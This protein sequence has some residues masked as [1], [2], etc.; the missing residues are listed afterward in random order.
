MDFIAQLYPFVALGNTEAVA[1]FLSSADYTADEAVFGAIPFGEALTVVSPTVSTHFLL[2]IKEA[3]ESTDAALA[4]PPK[5]DI[6]LL[7]TAEAP[8][9]KL[10]KIT[11]VLRDSASYPHIF[12]YSRED[13]LQN[14]RTVLKVPPER[15]EIIF[16]AIQ[17]GELYF[18]PHLSE[19]MAILDIDQTGLLIDILLEKIGPLKKKVEEG[20][21]ASVDETFSLQNARNLAKSLA[22]RAYHFVEPNHEGEAKAFQSEAVEVLTAG[23]Q[24][25]AVLESW[26]DENAFR[27]L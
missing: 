25:L 10:Q 11:A 6:Y 7:I 14:I 12:R 21:A 13:V 2:D 22:D 8:R 4:L 20:G 5:Q 26:L 3:S 15:M 1:H 23:L 19:E 9:E 17:T 24:A 16:R 27:D 18:G